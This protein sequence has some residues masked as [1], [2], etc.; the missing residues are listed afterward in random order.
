MRLC[1]DRAMA[2]APP[3]DIGTL[4]VSTP[5][6]N[7]GRPCIAG[8]GM[9]VH[10]VA[11]LFLDGRSPEEIVSEYPGVTHEGVYAAITHFLANRRQIVAELK[12]EADEGDSVLKSYRTSPSR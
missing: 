2:T 10:Q 8:T 1:Y 3:I 6:V 12:Q 11:A 5:G 7:G 9:S 4:I